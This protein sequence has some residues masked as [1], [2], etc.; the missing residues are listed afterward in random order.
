[1]S[2]RGS[3]TAPA[4]TSPASGNC[5]AGC[6][7]SQ[8]HAGHVGVRRRPPDAHAAAGRLH[9]RR[10]VGLRDGP[11]GQSPPRCRSSSCHWSHPAVGARSSIGTT[12]SCS[13]RCTPGLPSRALLLT[14]AILSGRPC[15]ALAGALLM[16]VSLAAGS[17]GWSLG[18]NDFAPRGEETR[19]MALHVTLTG[20]RGLMAPP[21]AILAYYGLQR[22]RPG[23]EAGR[24]CCRWHMIALGAWQFTAIRARRTG[25][26]PQAGTM[27]ARPGDPHGQA[28]GGSASPFPRRV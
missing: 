11:D 28:Q 18:H 15:A 7:F 16:G 13:A 19:Y 5:C 12:S 22:A 27:S 3:A 23:F 9:R 20:L 26:S 25:L 14:V 1:M 17:L 8:L 4:S 10:P 21:L 6:D 24:C 2:S